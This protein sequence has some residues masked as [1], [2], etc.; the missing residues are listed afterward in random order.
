MATDMKK[1]EAD[2]GFQV[3]DRRFWVEDEKASEEAP[4]PQQ[5]YP[6]FV[7]ELKARTEA[8]EQK[9]RERIEQLEQENKAFR[10]RLEKQVEIRVKSA[11]TEFITELLDVVDNLELALEKSEEHSDS[12]VNLREGIDL[13]LNLFLRKLKAV[14]VEPINSLH[15]DFDPN[16]S[17]AVGVVPID[18]PRLDQKVVILLQKG[19]RLEDRVIRPAKVQVGQFSDSH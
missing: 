1:N 18:D 3:S 4:P 8:A 15:Q 16:E 17:E 6:S 5:K 7:E 14:G 13:T 19:Y 2:R 10:S 12:V 11:I 9:L